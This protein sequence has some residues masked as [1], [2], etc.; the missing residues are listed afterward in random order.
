[1]G[2]VS[3]PHY[4]SRGLDVR[5]RLARRERERAI[6]R[7]REYRIGTE[8][9]G[10]ARHSSRWSSGARVKNI[11]SVFRARTTRSPSWQRINVRQDPW[12]AAT[13]RANRSRTSLPISSM[14][15][16]PTTPTISRS[17]NTG[18]SRSRR[19][20]RRTRT[21]SRTHAR[22]RRPTGRARARAATAPLRFLATRP[23]NVLLHPTHAIAARRGQL[24]EI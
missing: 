21:R 7:E 5:I 17:K 16:I 14:H 13:R 6:S 10:L 24:R 20:I 15:A 3:R 1:M 8:S 4:G 19:R 22:A 18:L 12:P 23:L 11:S 2:G 9:S